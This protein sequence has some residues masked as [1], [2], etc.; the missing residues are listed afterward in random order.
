MAMYVFQELAP[1]V[2]YFTYCLQEPEKYINFIE[3]S[4]SDSSNKNL[5]SKWNNNRKEVSFDFSNE[6]LPID[7]RSLYLVNSLKATL[8]FCFSEYKKF[9]NIEEDVN[10]HKTIILDK[11]YEGQESSISGSGKYVAVLYINNTYQDGNVTIDGTHV[12]L[13]PEEVS[14]IVAP[15]GYKINSSAPVNGTRYIAFGEWV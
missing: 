13:K 2:F 7:S 4:E 1:K 11:N 5:I 14:V 6:S 12:S 10:L 15:A 3:E 9:N 8:H